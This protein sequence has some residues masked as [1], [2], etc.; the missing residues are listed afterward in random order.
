[1]LGRRE[2]ARGAYRKAVQMSLDELKNN[3][4]DATTMA[5]LAV[6][7]AKLADCVSAARSPKSA[8]SVSPGVADVLYSDAVVNALCGRPDEALAALRQAL[9]KGYSAEFAKNDDDLATLRQRPGYGQ[10]VLGT[11]GVGK[12]EGK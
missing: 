4:K 12:G 1:M 11:R 3:P 10:L 6:Y 8:L 7:Q 9:A 2:E 5:C